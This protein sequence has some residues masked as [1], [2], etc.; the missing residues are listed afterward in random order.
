[1]TRVYLADILDFDVHLDRISLAK[2][3]TGFALESYTRIYGYD[4]DRLF[5]HASR[6]FTRQIARC[7][8]SIWEIYDGILSRPTTVLQNAS[9]TIRS[10][11]ARLHVSLVL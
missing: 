2:P 6:V 10:D 3:Y 4:L 5:S 9:T 7:W 11:T 8:I 1:M